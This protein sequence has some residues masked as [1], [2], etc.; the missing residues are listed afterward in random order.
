MKKEGGSSR[1]E[2]NA[3]HDGI[4]QMSFRR[5][6]PPRLA[7][8][9]KRVFLDLSTCHGGFYVLDFLPFGVDPDPDSDFRLVSISSL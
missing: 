9:A 1:S 6:S 3:I 2:C 4:I 5:L 8:Q 7:L